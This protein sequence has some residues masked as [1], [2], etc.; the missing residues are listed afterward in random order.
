MKICLNYYGLPRK[1]EVAKNTFNEYISTPNNNIN[2][3]I[4]YTTWENENVD[5]FKEIFQNSYI[6]FIEKPDL[7][8]YDYIINNYTLDHTNNYK[9][10]EHHVLGLYIKKMSY[11]TII[12]FENNNNINFDF[13]IT[14]RTDVYLNNHLSNFY[15]II[16]KNLNN[17]VYVANSPK[18]SIYNQPSLPIVIFISDKETSK[19][20]LEELDIL[21]N[22]NIKDTNFFHP[23]SSFYNALSFL[24]INIIE[25]NLFAFPQHITTI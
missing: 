6:N 10:I 1:L 5:E 13:I 8:K 25:L 9:S 11:N 19:K 17:T 24:K 14:L 16:N 7:K 3:Y 12:N 21:V 20:I 2:Y 22:C 15:S 18:F 23:E 4:L